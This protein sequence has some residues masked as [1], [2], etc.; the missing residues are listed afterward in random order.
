MILNQQFSKSFKFSPA[1]AYTAQFGNGISASFSM[2]DATTRRTNITTST[3]FGSAATSTGIQLFGYFSPSS[4]VGICG[5]IV[6]TGFP[7][8]ACNNNLVVV[9]VGI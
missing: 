2:E 6:A 3:S 7:V 9:P 4:N 8:N 1:I 5:P